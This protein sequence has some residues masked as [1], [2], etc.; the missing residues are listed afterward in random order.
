VLGVKVVHGWSLIRSGGAVAAAAALF[1][2]ILG[3]FALL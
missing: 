3:L 1:A 2:A